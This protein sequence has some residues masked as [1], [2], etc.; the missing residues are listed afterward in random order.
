MKKF[1]FLMLFVALLAVV[2]LTACGDKEVSGKA[3]AVIQSDYVG[4]AEITVKG[5]KVTA[6]KFDEV[7]LPT[8]WAQTT[9]E[10]DGLT[11]SYAGNYGDV[12]V[13]KYVMVGD[14]KFT[15]VLNADNTGVVY[16][17]DGIADLKAYLATEAN[18]KWY[19]EQVLAG[20][21]KATDASW[22]K[23]SF[24]IYGETT[25]WTKLTS[26]Y[27]P[28]GGWGQGYEANIKALQDAL[29][30][31]SMNLYE[32]NFTINT[33][34]KV[35]LDTITTTATI[36]GYKEYYALAKAAYNNAK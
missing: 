25:G 1:N 4:V 18:A 10:V 2:T 36:T 26:G 31:T 5:E 17:A 22:A 33:E 9:A 27:W 32:A 16:S 21:A 19:A 35:V 23:A 8:Q 13:A 11:L 7:Y 28:T 3:Y 34:N 20:N 29:I 30:G 12:I 24:S 15:G 14:K 6:L